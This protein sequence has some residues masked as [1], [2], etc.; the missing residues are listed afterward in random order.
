MKRKPKIAFFDFAGC[1]G[2]QLQVANLEETLLDVLGH[3]EVVSFREVMTGHSDDYDIALVEGSITRPEDEERLKEIRANAKILVAFGACATIG[4]VN[5]MKNFMS[6]TM[7]RRQVYGDNAR[8]Y[9]TY[10]ARPLSAVVKVD[11]EI[12]GCP[13]DRNEF[14]RIIKDLIIGK[15]PF[16]PDYPVCAECKQAGNICRYDLGQLCLGMITRAGCGACCINEGAHCWGCRGL[17]PMANLDAARY[18]M[19][20]R[21]GYSRSEVQDLLRIF[22]SHTTAPL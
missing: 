17:A 11:A 20:E 10:A 13:I 16:V 3:V 14:L 21:A 5:A 12:H 19:E 9:S 2:D 22:L 6:E 1:E 4:G 7:Y 8:C 18:V 15:R